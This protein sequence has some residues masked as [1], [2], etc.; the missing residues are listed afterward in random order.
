MMVAAYKF[1]STLGANRSQGGQRNLFAEERYPQAL[2][3]LG[4]D[5]RARSG[6]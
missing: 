4:A 2:P 6:T 5:I 1:A 3:L